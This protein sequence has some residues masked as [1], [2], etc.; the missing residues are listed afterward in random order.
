MKKNLFSLL[1]VL[2]ITTAAVAQPR[3]DQSNVNPEDMAKRQTAQLK[4]VLDLTSAQEKKV[5]DIN[6]ESG[7]KMRALRQEMQG[8]GFEAMREKMGKIREEQN[9]KMKEVLT[10]EQW[11]KYEKYQEERREQRNQRRND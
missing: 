3:G 9:K 6:L 11:K 5:Y 10:A 1:L 7:K 8:S 2:I 4:E